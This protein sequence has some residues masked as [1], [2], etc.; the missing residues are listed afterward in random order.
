MEIYSQHMEIK[1]SDMCM[2]LTI[3][4]RN[5]YECKVCADAENNDMIMIDYLNPQVDGHCFVEGE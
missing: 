4:M 1:L 2:V 5:G 3:L